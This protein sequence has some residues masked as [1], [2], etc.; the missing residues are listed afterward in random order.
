MHPSPVFRQQETDESYDFVRDHPFALLAVNG[1][2]GPLTALVPLIL[3]QPED[4]EPAIL[5]GHVASANPFWRAAENGPVDAVAVFRGADAYVSPSTYPSKQDDGRVVP[6][7]NYIAVEIRGQLSLAKDTSDVRAS[8]SAL[9]D[10]MESHRDVPWQVSDAPED[11]IAGLTRA[12]VGIQLSMR[13]ITYVRK[14][15]Q[16][17]TERDA[18]AVR[19]VFAASALDN[20]SALAAEMRKER[21]P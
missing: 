5:L 11:Y 21:R 12:I 3:S 14:L 10:H 13:Q 2:G 4:N 9:T 1:Q 7:W 8:L 20:E 19:T 18:N 15:S 6:T 16:N 17:K